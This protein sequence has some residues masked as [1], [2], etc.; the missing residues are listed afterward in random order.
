MV[1]LD[2]QVKKD[3][4]D[5]EE[6]LDQEVPLE[7]RVLKDLMALMVHQDLLALEE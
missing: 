3:L 5:Q 4:M 1:S 2:L 7:E 6:I